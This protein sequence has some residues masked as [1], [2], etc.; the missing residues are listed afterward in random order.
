MP[1]SSSMGTNSVDSQVSSI[2]DNTATISKNVE[3]R[4]DF[5]LVDPFTNSEQRVTDDDFSKINL[6][7]N[8][9]AGPSKAIVL[10]S[11]KNISGINNQTNY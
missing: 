11:N 8:G 3:C 10:D 7:T 9:Q 2:F 4:G 5:I 6:I 1:A